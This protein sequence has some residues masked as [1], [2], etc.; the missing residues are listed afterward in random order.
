[1]EENMDEQPDMADEMSRLTGSALSSSV[2]YDKEG[3]VLSY[4]QA[5]KRTIGGPKT[6]NCRSRIFQLL[7]IF[8]AVLAL[9]SCNFLIL[10]LPFMKSAPQHFTCKDR[11]TGEWHSCD[12]Q[13]ICSNGLSKD[14]YRAD[15][16]DSQYIDNW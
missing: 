16:E 13:Y 10:G 12:K 1:M 6:R 9:N 3:Q 2:D 7:I 5:I 8:I 15:T 4:N 11:D 14:E